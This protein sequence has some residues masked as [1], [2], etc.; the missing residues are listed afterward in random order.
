MYYHEERKWYEPAWDGL[1]LSANR[2]RRS[3]S[4]ET[5]F[6]RTQYGAGLNQARNEDLGKGIFDALHWQGTNPS[7][8]RL[9]DR[10]FAQGEAGYF[11]GILLAF[12]VGVFLRMDYSLSLFS[13]PQS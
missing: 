8:P 1:N 6:P 5:G 2:A 7:T 9:E 13:L 3:T 12:W 11:T 4:S 10:G